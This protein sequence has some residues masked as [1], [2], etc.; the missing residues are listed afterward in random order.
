MKYYQIR[1]FET[2]HP[3]S[4]D[5]VMSENDLLWRLNWIR[6]LDYMRDHMSLKTWLNILVYGKEDV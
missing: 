2:T 4:H 1:E 5:G 6:T 3:E